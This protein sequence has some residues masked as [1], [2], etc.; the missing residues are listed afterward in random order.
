MD[1]IKIFFF[2]SLLIFCLNVFITISL[3][4]LFSG[5]TGR[6]CLMGPDVLIG[7]CNSCEIIATNHETLA[8]HDGFCISVCLTIGM[9]H[10][11]VFSFMHSVNMYSFFLSCAWCG[12][13]RVHVSNPALVLKGPTVRCS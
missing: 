8:C 4:L 6:S 10:A 12:C 5:K 3:Q 13:G 9:T 11:L 2:S 1:L 7:Y